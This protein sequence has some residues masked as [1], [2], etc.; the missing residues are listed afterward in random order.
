[1]VLRSWQ[2]QKHPV[3]KPPSSRLPTLLHRIKLRRI[4]RKIHDSKRLP[5]RNQ[6]PIK[7]PVVTRSI[8]DE[9]AN[10][11]PPQQHLFQEPHKR[12]LI[13]ALRERENKRTLASR[14]KNVRTLVFAVN[15]YGTAAAFPKPSALYYGQKAKGSFVLAA[16]YPTS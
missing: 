15:H 12:S 7:Y 2:R 1:M 13:L 9:Q 6:E 10:P 4:L 11:P 5:M 16:N 3:R 8:I 14:S